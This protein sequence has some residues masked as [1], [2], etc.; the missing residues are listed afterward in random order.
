MAGGIFEIA[1]GLARAL[2]ELNGI[3][4]SVLGLGDGHSKADFSAWF[5]VRPQTFASV[6]PKSYGFSPR[7]LS[8]IRATAPDLT[9]VHGIWMYPSLA[10]HRWSRKTQRPY[11]ITIHGMLDEWALNNASWKKRLVAGLFEKRVLLGASALHVNSRAELNALRNYG[12]T[13]PVVV[14]PNGVELPASNGSEPAPW[15]PG[16]RKNE[17]ILL[18]LGRLHP[19]KNLSALMRGWSVARRKVAEKSRPWRLVI[20]GWD[21]GGH[22]AALRSLAGSLGISSSVEFIGPQFNAQKVAAFRNASAVVLP[23]LSE[24][25]PMSVLEAWSFGRP[26]LMT[27]QCNLSDGFK[28]GAALPIDTDAASLATSLSDLFLMSETSRNEIGQRG[29]DLVL[30]KFTWRRVAQDMLAAYRWILRDGERP[31]FAH[32]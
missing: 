25:Q 17:N 31:E 32:G 9:H 27:A 21:D 6:P 18:Y 5:P 15:R 13:N 14:I 11:L 4:A 19:K 1:R 7:L 20:A 12:L 26:V 8:G 29:Y 28:A 22:G 30:E 2:A 23:S 10:A 3:D 16:G 24:G